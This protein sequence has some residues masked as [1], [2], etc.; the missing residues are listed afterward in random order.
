MQHDTHNT[1]FLQKID[2]EVKYIDIILQSV[3]QIKDDSY[4]LVSAQMKRL[5]IGNV[6]QGATSAT[7]IENAHDNIIA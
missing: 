4:M 7:E 6:H 2:K 1:N 5:S 3:A